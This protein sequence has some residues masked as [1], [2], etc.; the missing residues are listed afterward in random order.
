[1]DLDTIAP[2]GGGVG[3][4]DVR[5]EAVSFSIAESSGKVRRGTHSSNPSRHTSDSSVIA[6]EAALRLSSARRTGPTGTPLIP[7]YHSSVF[8]LVE[9]TAIAADTADGASAGGAT[10]AFEKA[11]A[12][13]PAPGGAAGLGGGGLRGAGT[14]GRGGG[15]P[16]TPG[17]RGGGSD[18]DPCVGPCVPSGR[19]AAGGSPVEASW[20]SLE[21]T[22]VS[23][24]DAVTSMRCAHLR[25]F[26]RTV[27]PATLSSAIWYFALQFSQRNFMAGGLARV[28][29]IGRRFR[30]AIIARRR[31]NRNRAR[32][33]LQRPRTTFTMEHPHPAPFPSTRAQMPDTD[34]RRWRAAP[35]SRGCRTATDCAA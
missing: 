27:R 31:C 4:S 2:A 32:S 1:M 5:G 18:D 3:V 23:V 21:A 34:P 6:P 10:T 33:R 30:A 16:G 20:G 24:T 12:R 28:E 13:P 19:A 7:T 8:E 17:V 14:A 9:S 25:H 29:P 35:T 22:D 26:I 11:P 15:R